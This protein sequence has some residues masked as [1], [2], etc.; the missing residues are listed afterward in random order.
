[1]ATED[2][3]VRARQANAQARGQSPRSTRVTSGNANSSS[4]IDKLKNARGGVRSG[5][6]TAGRV[7]GATA[8]EGVGLGKTFVEGV[9]EGAGIKEKAA[10]AT[11]A[12]ASKASEGLNAARGAAKKI[13]GAVGRF[14]GRAALGAGKLAV[15]GVGVALLANQ[16]RKSTEQ[17]QSQAGGERISPLRGEGPGPVNLERKG[18]GFDTSP[19]TASEIARGPTGIPS[20]LLS[21]VQI[22]DS[23]LAAGQAGLG[24]IRGAFDPTADTSPVAPPP[25][26]A[27]PPPTQTG[28]GV[29][30][31]LGAAA[32]NA[33]AQQ[34]ARSTFTGSGTELPKSGTGFFTNTAGERTNLGTPDASQEQGLRGA[35]QE[36]A[37]PTQNEEILQKLSDQAREGGI[38]SAFGGL[39]AGGNVLREQAANRQRQFQTQ[40]NEQTQQNKI[41]IE[42]TKAA[43][44]AGPDREKAFAE[45]SRKT[46]QDL[47]AAEGADDSGASL[48]R[49]KDNLAANSIRDING[50][51]AAIFS[52]LVSQELTELSDVSKISNLIGLGDGR[53]LFDL[54]SES[55]EPV[56]SLNPENS[57]FFDRASGKIQQRSNTEKEGVQDLVDFDALPKR[58]QDFL[59]AKGILVSKNAKG[60][61]GLRGGGVESSGRLR[62]Q[63]GLGQ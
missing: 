43:A 56:V 44:K 11:K 1:M 26:A 41:D 20:A 14:A 9:A 10:K 27:A 47:T 63:V 39:A 45:E 36:E 50:P 32:G 6:G 58:T 8:A 54:L 59:R 31:A 53:N 51:Q 23:V 33:G 21:R 46:L 24:A 60:E 49:L 17:L 34:G 35:Q 37:A 52:G 18:F 22:P 25:S 13:P 38:A 5:V 48:S 29:T 30:Q 55:Q 2:E 15:P 62:P 4:L 3:K 28:G 40:E 57:V 42:L 12:G 19:P 7:A 61:K 16:A